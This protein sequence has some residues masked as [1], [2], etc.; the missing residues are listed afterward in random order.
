MTTTRSVAPWLV[1]TEFNGATDYGVVFTAEEADRLMA[2]VLQEAEPLWLDRR[3]P[4]VAFSIY[5]KTL[6]VTRDKAILG[7]VD[8]T[9]SPCYRYGSPELAVVHPWTGT[10]EYLRDTIEAHTGVRTNHCVL[11]RYVDGQDQIGFHTDKAKDFT[12]DYS[13]ITLSFGGTRTLRLR[14]RA[15]K[16]GPAD[17]E[18]AM[19]H[20]SAY[21]L[22]QEANETYKHSVL[23]EGGQAAVRL[24]LTFRTVASVYDS[25]TGKVETAAKRRRV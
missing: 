2:Q 1:R 22:S 14:E 8:G 24:G 15:K 16:S 7:D 9:R 12:D 23:R 25:E 21:R 10:M 3:D 18:L 11:N 20:G 19:T 13:I 5:G 4:S 6:G 17:W